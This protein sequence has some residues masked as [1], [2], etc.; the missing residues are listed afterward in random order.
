MPMSS[1]DFLSFLSPRM[2]AAV[3]PR[4]ELDNMIM[5]DALDRWCASLAREENERLEAI[6]RRHRLARRIRRG[7][8]NAPK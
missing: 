8:P 6:E 3:E 1:L 4:I 5:A 7:W 2:R